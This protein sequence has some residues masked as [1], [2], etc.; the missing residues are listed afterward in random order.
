MRFFKF[1]TEAIYWVAFFSS[2]TLIFCIG[3]FLL[4]LYNP[5][6]IVL[7]IVIVI[8][9]MTFGTLLAEKIRKKYGCSNYFS[10]LLHMPELETY[11]DE[12]N[13]KKSS[14]QK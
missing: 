7:S 3:A 5:S 4:Y 10:K 12:N 6:L 9:G 11:D 13:F 1:I 14:N 8:L 2:P